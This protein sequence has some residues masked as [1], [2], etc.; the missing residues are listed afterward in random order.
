MMMDEA[1]DGTRRLIAVNDTPNDIELHYTV[2]DAYD[3]YFVCAGDVVIP[4]DSAI[5]ATTIPSPK[6]EDRFY[7][8]EWRDS[9]GLHGLNPYYTL[10]F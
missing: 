7:L 8:I 3:P 10:T 2:R 6:G 5:T 4:A 9:Y 1:E